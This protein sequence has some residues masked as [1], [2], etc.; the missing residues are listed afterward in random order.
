MTVIW[1]HSWAAAVNATYTQT[2]RSCRSIA[3]N[4]FHWARAHERGPATGQKKDQS[5]QRHARHAAADR[6]TSLDAP[7]RMATYLAKFVPNFSEVTAKLLSK[8]VEHRWDDTIHC[9]AL[10]KI[11]DMLMTSPVLRY[12]DVSKPLLIQ[13]DPSSYGHGAAM[14]IDSQPVEYSWR[15]MTHTYKNGRKLKNNFC[16]FVSLRTGFIRTFMGART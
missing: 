11:K 16:R 1:P 7:F 14:I 3:H 2:K 4:N 13:C 6:P 9:A 10:R 15:S 8:D 12:Y 5:H